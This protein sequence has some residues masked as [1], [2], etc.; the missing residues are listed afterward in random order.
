MPV[1]WVGV[2]DDRRICNTKVRHRTKAEAR[3]A[4]ARDSRTAGHRL[5]IYECP[6]CDGFHLTS[7]PP[8]HERHRRRAAA[9]G[10]LVKISYDAPKGVTLEL[11]D[12][13]R[14]PTGRTY[15]IVG[16]R[17][18]DKGKHRGRYHLQCAVGEP[19]PGRTFLLVWYNRDPATTRY[20]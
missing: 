12:G 18:Q 8:E 14:T 15:L 3:A 11:G 7:M 4:R 1:T 16:L 9:A 17:V 6:T 2:E 13:L 20:P 10:E 5:H 19:I